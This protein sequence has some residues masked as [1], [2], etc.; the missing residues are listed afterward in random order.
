[1][2]KGSEEKNFLLSLVIVISTLFVFAIFF[3]HFVVSDLSEATNLDMIFFTICLFAIIKKE[4]CL[5]KIAC[6]SFL[7]MSLISI[8]YVFDSLHKS[9]VYLIICF[10]HL[11]FFALL[12]LGIIILSKSKKESRQLDESILKCFTE[13]DADTKRGIGI[14][15]ALFALMQIIP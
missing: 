10:I 9:P 11:A 7:L 12:W 13:L 5:A 8:T 15:T 3:L 6:F 4:L 2:H 1:M 14:I